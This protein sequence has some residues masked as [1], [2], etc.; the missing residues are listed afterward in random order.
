MYVIDIVCVH[1]CTCSLVLSLMAGYKINNFIN[2]VGGTYQ[3]QKKIISSGTN[4]PLQF[5]NQSEIY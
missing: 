1:A 5:T 3:N 4:L 2:T